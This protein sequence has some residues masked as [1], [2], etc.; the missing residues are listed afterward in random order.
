[1]SAR[2][3][4]ELAR[5]SDEP[6]LRNILRNTSMQ[7]DVSLSFEREPNYL[8]AERLGNV[9]TQI[10]VGRDTVTGDI[11]GCGSR[12]IREA[13]VDGRSMRIGY[14]GGLRILPEA[15]GGSLLVRGYRLFR[16]LHED[17]EVPFYITSILNGNARA[18]K[19][20]TG[21][22][23]GLP[24]YAPLGKMIT[25]LIPLVRFRSRRSTGVVRMA[26]C[27]HDV[28]DVVG[29]INAYNRRW[30]FAPAYSEDDF[31]GGVKL[32]GFS[33]EN[34]YVRS[35]DG[36]ILG[37]IGVWDQHDFKQTVIRSYSGLLTRMRPFYNLYAVS[38]AIPQLPPVG[39][40]VR[41]LYGSFA[42]VKD[43][44]PVVFR[45]LLDAVRRDWSGKGYS[46]L[47]VGFHEAH[48][49]A[50]MLVRQSARVIKSTL[51]LV[52]W[53]D[54]G[55]RFELSRRIPHVEISTL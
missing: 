45:S 11:V 19:A 49:L 29:T 30:Q 43:D 16:S 48:P 54:D 3:R 44:D 39:S 47:T 12:S 42:S 51:Y 10:V 41:N 20:L 53:P 17:N 24:I 27:S 14:L 50:R 22:R 6:A 18:E 37:T 25:G 33:A 1:M 35:N 52:H 21:A 2:F 9:R 32:R 26:E 5:E 34:L 31:R 38:C 13:Y 28:S 7:G 46:Y 23:A 4:F 15:Q 8:M 55:Q 40:F 36:E